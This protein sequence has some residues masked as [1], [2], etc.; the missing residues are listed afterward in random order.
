[1]LFAS[2]HIKDV[3]DQHDSWLDATWP[4][5]WGCWLGFSLVTLHIP[6]LFTYSWETC[7]PLLEGRVPTN[8]LEFFHTGNLSLL[9]DLLSHSIIYFDKH[10]L[11]NIYYLLWVLIRHYLILLLKL[12]QLWPLEALLVSS[13]ISLKYPHPRELSKVFGHFYTLCFR[14]VLRISC[15]S[16]G[17]SYFCKKPWFLLL[18][19]GIRNQDPGTRCAHRYWGLVSFRSSQLRKKYISVLYVYI[20]N[21]SM[22]IYTHST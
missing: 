21:N 8:H 4:L 15:P 10:G 2:Y 12:L 16:S 5:G 11:M 20:C 19:T 1:M 18:K 22:H 13:C 14:L 9:P 3:Y 6:P 17:V 7:F